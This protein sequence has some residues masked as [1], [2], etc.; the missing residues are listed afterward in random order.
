MR[1][2]LQPETQQVVLNWSKLTSI[3]LILEKLIGLL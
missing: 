1:V 2:V 3:T